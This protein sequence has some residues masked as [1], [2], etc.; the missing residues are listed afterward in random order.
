MLLH[1][2]NDVP[3]IREGIESRGFPPEPPPGHSALESE[4]ELKEGVRRFLYDVFVKSGIREGIERSV[5]STEVWHIVDIYLESEKELKVLLLIRLLVI[6]SLLESE[7][8]L[9]GS[10]IGGIHEE[11]RLSGIREGI[12]S[13]F[14]VICFSSH[15]RSR[16]NPR[17]N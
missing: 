12:E 13:V 15:S 11:E 1:E 17:R 7:K 16:W 5:P 3:G 14:A 10:N 2:F 6:G 8:E 4:K 9:K